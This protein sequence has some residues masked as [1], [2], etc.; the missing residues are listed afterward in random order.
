VAANEVNQ[1]EFGG[2]DPYVSALDF[3]EQWRGVP[4][5]GEWE[6]NDDN[7]EVHCAQH[8][9]LNHG[10]SSSKLP[11]LPRSDFISSRHVETL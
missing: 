4:S 9:K 3:E 8:D 7:I 1:L 6:L 11:P 5:E 10:C 2:Q